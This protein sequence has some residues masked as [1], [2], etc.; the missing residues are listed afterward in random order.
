VRVLTTLAFVGF[1]SQLF[2]LCQIMRHG[3]NN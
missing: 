3:E 2:T 1:D